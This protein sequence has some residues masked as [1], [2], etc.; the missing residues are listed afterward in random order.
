MDQ[1]VP[2]PFTGAGSSGAS[3]PAGCSMS[4]FLF[5]ISRS[6]SVHYSLRLRLARLFQS[7]LSQ[8]GSD[9][10]SVFT[11]LYFL[12]RVFTFLSV[13]DL[14]EHSMEEESSSGS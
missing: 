13:S 11:C 9:Y 2:S 6:V 12:G 4:G 5:L 3:T 10:Q 1:R 7:S 14:P 8:Y